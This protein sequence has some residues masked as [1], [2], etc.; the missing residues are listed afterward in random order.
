[1]NNQYYDRPPSAY[2]DP[3]EVVVKHLIAQVYLQIKR[4][5]VQIIDINRVSTLNLRFIRMFNSQHDAPVLVASF[6]LLA[7][8]LLAILAES[9][10]EAAIVDIQRAIQAT[11]DRLARVL[12]ILSPLK[13]VEQSKSYVLN[14][15][16]QLA[17]KGLE[18]YSN[19][20]SYMASCL[21]LIGEHKVY[22]IKRAEESWLRGFHTS[23]QDIA[24]L[25]KI[26]STHASIADVI[27]SVIIQTEYPNQCQT[28]LEYE[29]QPG[30]S[31]KA[32]RARKLRAMDEGYFLLGRT[33]AIIAHSNHGHITVKV[34]EQNPVRLFLKTFGI[35]AN[36]AQWSTLQK[37]MQLRA[38]H[39]LSPGEFAARMASSV[40]T[41]FKHALITSVI[42]RKGVMHGGAIEHCMRQQAQYLASD[43]PALYAKDA[44]EKGTLFGFGH[45]I[46]KIADSNKDIALGSDPR[47]EIMFRAIKSSFPEKLAFIGKLEQFAI[48]VQNQ[49]STLSPNTDFVS[50]IL[51]QCLGIGPREGSGL[52]LAARLPGLIAEIINQLAYKANSLR[53]PLPVTLPYD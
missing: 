8:E 35:Q 41:S 12:E 18:E 5:V 51:F 3:R 2:H 27:I 10:P 13:H 40:R 4:S 9:C 26:N 38:S 23:D 21:E 50:G 44:L 48:Q 22:A 32:N 19:N 6:E 33:M 52:F 39:G 25:K 15:V 49:K 17:G 1:M 46:H 43:N 30:L 29:K 53:P 28:L 20:P 14:G 47:V 42:T 34:P 36:D 31:F 11:S 24:L 45:R 16:V 37:L 7:G